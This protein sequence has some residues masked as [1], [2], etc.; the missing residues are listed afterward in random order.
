MVQGNEHALRYLSLHDNQYVRYFRGHTARVSA[1]AMSPK[2]DLFMS[3]AEVRAWFLLLA[4]AC[5]LFGAGL[6]PRERQRIWRLCAVVQ[7]HQVRLWDLRSTQ[8]QGLVNCPG[9][10]TAAFDQQGLVFC[11]GSDSGVL[12]LY[13]VRSYDK[14]PFDTFTVSITTC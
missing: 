2:N 6:G 4:T 1:L 12:K 10:A 8:C 9:P 3:A 5:A 7:D 14:G 11:I 13:D